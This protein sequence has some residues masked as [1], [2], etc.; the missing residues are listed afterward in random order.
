MATRPIEPSS[1]CWP[2]WRQRPRRRP[3]RR[4]ACQALPA[5]ACGAREAQ[6]RSQCG[7][8]VPG[9]ELHRRLVCAKAATPDGCGC[10]APHAAAHH[11][12]TLATTVQ[13]TAGQVW[14]IPA[15]D[16]IAIMLQG[17]CVRVTARLPP[18]FLP[19]SQF[20]RGEQWKAYCKTLTLAASRK[21]RERRRGQAWGDGAQ[22]FL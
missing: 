10:G 2:A 11:P 5:A 22:L 16:H 17:T 20:T 1:C 18:L 8:Q 7:G 9:A 6:C 12:C 21:P 15:A 4:G 14:K 19:A 3:R 13:L